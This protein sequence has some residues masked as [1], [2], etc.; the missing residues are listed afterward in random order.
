MPATSEQRVSQVNSVN[1]NQP[2]R[3]MWDSSHNRWREVGSLQCGRSV[4]YQDETAMN[5]L[6]CLQVEIHARLP[7]RLERMCQLCNR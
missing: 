2:K 5:P 7:A 3:T 1:I 4:Y 6:L